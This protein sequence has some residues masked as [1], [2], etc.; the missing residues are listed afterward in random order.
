MYKAN[1]LGEDTSEYSSERFQKQ[2]K[3]VKNLYLNKL[4]KNSA[5]Y[6]NNG[7][8][9]LEQAKSLIDDAAE[10]GEKERNHM[11]EN[12][13]VIIA[14]DNAV[15]AQKLMEHLVDKNKIEDINQYEIYYAKA[16]KSNIQLFAKNKKIEFTLIFYL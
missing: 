15:A 11:I 6:Y 16:G 1:S 12:L 13:S 10:I 3:N 2:F 9:T 5:I 4:I 8:L 14:K 7:K